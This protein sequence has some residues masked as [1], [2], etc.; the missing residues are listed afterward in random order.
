MLAGAC[1]ALGSRVQVR[2]TLAAPPG[3]TGTIALSV[4]DASTGR[5]V[6]TARACDGLV[7]A[8]RQV[9]RDCGPVTVSLPR[10]RTYLVVMS[11]TY[12]RNG[13]GARGTQNGAAFAWL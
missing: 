6:A 4:R 2:G 1:H 9:T 5:T 7:F 12:T 13:A 10:G 3:G 11:W 8:D